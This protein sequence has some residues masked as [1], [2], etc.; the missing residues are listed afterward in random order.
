MIASPVVAAL[1][2][3]ADAGTKEKIKIEIQLPSF[4]FKNAHKGGR[5]ILYSH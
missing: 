3:F 4:V 5:V 2:G 1:V